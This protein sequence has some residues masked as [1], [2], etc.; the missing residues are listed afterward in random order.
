MNAN[1][2]GH[3]DLPTDWK[4]SDPRRALA[5]TVNLIS[6]RS[7]QHS[8]HLDLIEHR[9]DLLEH[10]A[11]GAWRVTL[12]ALGAALLNVGAALVLLITN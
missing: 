2:R 9:L 1:D 10:L 7:N 5:P 8:A 11:T 6:A 3:I 4:D 12:V